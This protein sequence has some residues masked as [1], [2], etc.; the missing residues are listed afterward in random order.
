MPNKKPIIAESIKDENGRVLLICEYKGRRLSL[1][2]NKWGEML[3]RDYKLIK[4]AYYAGHTARVCLGLDPWP[5]PL[6]AAQKAEHNKQ[7]VNELFD[8]LRRRGLCPPRNEVMS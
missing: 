8:K 1:T 4:R 3:D 2:F 5:E 7:I 6:K